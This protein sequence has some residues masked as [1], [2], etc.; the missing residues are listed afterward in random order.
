ME[1]FKINQ[2][3]D[4]SVFLT[5]STGKIYLPC[6]ADGQ[7]QAIDLK[8]ANFITNFT[9]GELIYSIQNLNGGLGWIAQAIQAGASIFG[10]I[11]SSIS[12][13]KANASA[14]RQ[15]QLQ[16]QALELQQRIQQQ[17]AAFELQMNQSKSTGSSVMPV[18]LVGLAGLS[19]VGGIVFLFVNKK[20]EKSKKNPLK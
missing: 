17:Q 5:D 4:G 9:D 8:S 16:N 2:S 11:S 19:I 7:Y 20:K 14:E 18:V 6:T 3:S 12:A 10:S 13:K 1:K 15:M